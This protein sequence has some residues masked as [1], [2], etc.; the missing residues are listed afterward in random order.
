MMARNV[1]LKGL[2]I[3][4]VCSTVL[5]PAS[6][7]ALAQADPLDVEA[8][9]GWEIVP[10]TATASLYALDMVSATDGWIGGTSGLALH[11]DGTTWN[12][13]ETLFSDAFVAIDMVDANFGFATTYAGDIV[14]YSGGQWQVDKDLSTGSLTGISM[15]DANNG[16]AVG[17]LGGIYRYQNG[18]WQQWTTMPYLF[19]AI[20]M[21][22]ANDGWIMG[23]T[24][25]ILHWNGAAWN[26]VGTPQN[27]WFLDVDMISGSDGWA[28]GDEGII[29]HYNGSSWS[30]VSTPVPGIA[31]WSVSMSSSADGWAVGAGGTILHYNGSSWTQVTSPVTV[32]LHAV[33]VVSRDDAWAVGKSGTVL[34]SFGTT[35]LTS[36]TKSVSSATASPGDTLTYSIRV[37]NTGNLPAAGVVVTDPTPANASYVPAS[38]TTTQGTIQGTNPLVVAVGDVA[39]GAQ[40]TISFRVTVGNP[41]PTCWFLQNQATIAAVGEDPLVRRAVTSVGDCLRI[42]LPLVSR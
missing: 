36:S 4:V 6:P 26:V 27:L 16:W 28:V 20:D 35:D 3:L 24:G 2:L 5:L 40:V 37:R 34:H 7:G 14:R 21:V 9:G 12:D 38:A 10:I 13:F 31:L 1:L 25:V 22:S 17:Y 41:G 33:D 8:A 15:V 19:Q 18:T 32:E 42:Y 39:P 11:Y 23:R 29:Y 30:P